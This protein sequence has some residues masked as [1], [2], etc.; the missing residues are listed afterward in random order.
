MVPK[1]S[2]YAE[3]F[4]LVLVM[5]QVMVPP[6]GLHPAEGRIPG[7]NGIMHGAIQQVTQYKAGE[8][9]KSMLPHNHEHDGKKAGRYDEAWDR[10]DEEAFLIPGIMVVVAMHDIYNAA[11]PF[12]FSDHMK[13]PAVHDV[14]K[15]SP[16]KHAGQEKKGGLA[17][18]ETKSCHGKIGEADEH[19]QVHAPDHQGMGLGQKFKGGILKQLR[20]PLVMNFLKFHQ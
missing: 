13:N 9:H 16:E 6:Q 3:A 10:R 18:T 1:G 19:G 2:A 4:M 11:R 5:M 7:M 15:K 8:E 20:L 17:T 14:F 12:A